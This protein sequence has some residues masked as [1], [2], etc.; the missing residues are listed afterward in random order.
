MTT[1]LCLLVSALQ[2]LVLVAPNAR[3]QLPDEAM[4]V[5]CYAVSGRSGGLFVVDAA[6]SFTPI[7]GLPAELSFANCVLRDPARDPRTDHLIASHL[8][9]TPGGT[10]WI[11]ELAVARTSPNPP[12]YAATVVRSFNLGASNTTGGVIATVNQIAW[13]PGPGRRVVL[14]SEGI[15]SGPTAGQ[16]LWIL[17]LATGAL[18]PPPLGAWAGARAFNAVTV[19]ASGTHVYVGL[20]DR[21]QNHPIL[22][23]PLAGPGASPVAWVADPNTEW[24]ATGLA[25]DCRGNLLAAASSVPVQQSLGAIFRF[26]PTPNG[27]W[28]RSHVTPPL[29]PWQ[30]NA[31]VL[32]PTSCDVIVLLTGGRMFRV[33]PTGA[34]WL[35]ATPPAGIGVGSGIDLD[36]NPEPY[37]AACP[38]SGGTRLAWQFQPFPGGPPRAGS[39]TFHLA[40]QTSVPM[41]MSDV[42]LGIAPAALPIPPPIGC[43]LHVVPL[44]TLGVQNGS[45]PR[46]PLPIPP[47]PALIGAELYCQ[48]F[49]LDGTA[50][51]AGSAGLHFTI[52]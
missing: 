36:P 33:D 38:S 45:S 12:T 17:D 39:A 9:G 40:V 37:G 31:L 47:D 18:T 49:G 6:G 43:T 25:W 44:V 26:T 42:V 8:Q 50:N 21:G 3:A 27:P 30:A 13:L 41:I 4:V 29:V 15:A 35:V 5:A 11:H 51:V 52:Y 10:V 48:A 32:D 22:E 34:M 1:R 46:F 24:F 20:F 16:S 23:V 14:A 19:S 28:P 2:L 7:S